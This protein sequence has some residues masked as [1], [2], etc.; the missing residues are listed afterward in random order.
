MMAGLVA[1]RLRVEFSYYKL[2]EQTEVFVSTWEVSDV[3]CSVR[4][5]LL[6]VNLSY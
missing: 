3:L 6:T 5:N 1:A 2:T 4:D